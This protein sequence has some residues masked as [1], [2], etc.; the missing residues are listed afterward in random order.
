M[1]KVILT[2]SFKHYLQGQREIKGIKRKSLRLA[3][4]QQL[5]A[6]KFNHSYKNKIIRKFLI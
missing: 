1:I 5:I 3:S 2:F 6:T 4:N